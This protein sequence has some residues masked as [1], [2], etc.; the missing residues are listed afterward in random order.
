M[1]DAWG[2]FTLNQYELEWRG[3]PLLD[4]LD[5][6]SIVDKNGDT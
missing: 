6:V 3:N 1:L 4:V 2:G 5:R